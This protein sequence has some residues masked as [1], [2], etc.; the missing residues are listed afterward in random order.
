DVAGVDRSQE[1]K[2]HATSVSAAARR[3]NARRWLLRRGRRQG[4]ADDGGGRLARQTA[5]PHQDRRR[6]WTMRAGLAQRNE[7]LL[8]GAQERTA[9]V[10]HLADGRDVRS[11]DAREV[12]ERLPVLDL[13]RDQ[14]LLGAQGEQRLD[15]PAQLLRSR[16]EEA[17]VE[18][19]AMPPR[20]L[21]DGSVLAG[22]DAIDPGA[23]LSGRERVR[24]EHVL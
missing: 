15:A 11:I 10:V 7:Q 6:Q 18:V 5:R 16:R 14:V 20:M 12:P 9:H 2:Q 24:A 13:V 21:Q 22:E 1:K 17:D 23:I 3:E 8:P 19:I 4:E